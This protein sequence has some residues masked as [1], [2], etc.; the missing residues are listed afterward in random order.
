MERR[1]PSRAGTRIDTHQLSELLGEW[2]ADG[3]SAYRALAAS[4][5]RLVR[6]GRLSVTS[7]LPAERDLADALAVSRTTVASAYELLRAEG[8]LISRRGVGSFV[9][10]DRAPR[11]ASAVEPIDLS[12]AAMSAPE[13]WLSRATARAAAELSTYTDGHG[14]FP[15]GL[16]EL[17]V[18]IAA[19]YTE[20]GLPTDAGQIMVTNGATGAFTLL[21]RRF[22]AP[23]DRMVVEAPTHPGMLRSLRLA[24]I[25]PVPVRLREDG[26]DLAA[27]RETLHMTQSSMACLTPDFHAPT[28]L[29]MPHE[30]RRDLVALA[31]AAGVTLVADETVAE[32]SLKAALPPPLAAYDAS[33]ESGAVITVGSA[34]KAYWSG[35]RIGWIRADAPTVRHL[36]EQRLGLDVSCPVIDQLVLARLLGDP[37]V[38]AEV[39]DFQRERARAGR[40]TLVA[41]LRQELP[42]WTFRVPAGGLALWARTGGISAREVA[43]AAGRH[44]VRLAA[45]PHFNVAGGSPDDHVRLP[46][47][48]PPDVLAEAVRRLAGALRAPRCAA[49]TRGDALTSF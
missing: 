15:A 2:R 19:R 45:E 9:A 36:A 31:R 46:Y 24:G 25:R 42:A 40:D 47:T 32:L 38:Q 4:L 16:W 27:W 43:D 22:G 48:R 21:A 5:W 41:L 35:L 26:W 39:L 34:S 17:R 6:D 29:L 37:G 7:R 49:P 3:H 18:A 8:R 20:R 10:P 30:Q 33:D 23:G 11:S 44:G 12:V 13:P 14:A 28:G 1:E